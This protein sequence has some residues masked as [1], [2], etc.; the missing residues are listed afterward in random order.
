MISHTPARPRLKQVDGFHLLDQ[1]AQEH[2]IALGATESRT[3]TVDGVVKRVE[4][5]VQQVLPL[6]LY[7]IC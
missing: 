3:K 1:R 2:S 6:T 5:L 4:Q 7:R